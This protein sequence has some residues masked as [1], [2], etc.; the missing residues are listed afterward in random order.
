MSQE[1]EV[2]KHPWIHF[3][4]FIE[5]MGSDNSPAFQWFKNIHILIRCFVWG[6]IQ[7]GNYN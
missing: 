5:V 3:I 7:H 1:Q 6:R 2:T 4:T